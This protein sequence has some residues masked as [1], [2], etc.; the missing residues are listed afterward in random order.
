M[1]KREFERYRNLCI[2]LGAVSI[3]LGVSMPFRSQPGN[4]WQAFWT[5]TCTVGLLIL[6]LMQFRLAYVLHGRTQK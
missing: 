3:G 5:V 2:L 6:G 4:T 1:T